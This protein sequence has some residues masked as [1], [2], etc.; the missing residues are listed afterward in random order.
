M[1]G[2]VVTALF[3]REDEKF[4]LYEPAQGPVC[5][6]LCWTN[7]QGLES[8]AWEIRHQEVTPGREKLSSRWV[9]ALLPSL[10][11]EYDWSLYIDSRLRLNVSPLEIEAQYP[12]SE[13]VAFRHPDRTNLRDEAQ[14]I[15]RKNKAEPGKVMHQLGTYVDE[16]FGPELGTLTAGGFLFRRHTASTMAHGRIW[17]DEIKR[18]TTRDQMSLDYSLHK[19]GLSIDYF[20]GSYTRSPMVDWEVTRAIR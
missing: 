16:G 6:H 8:K 3:D 2:I 20:E 7:R 18:H 17:W 11:G 19:A 9:K 15:V 14:E 13:F 5:R 12:D 1:T 10:F 4:R